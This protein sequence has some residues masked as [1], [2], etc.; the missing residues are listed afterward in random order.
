MP[1]KTL[2]VADLEATTT[3]KDEPFLV[4]GKTQA[5]TRAGKT[6]LNLVLAD[7]TGRVDAKVWD[8]ADRWARLFEVGDAV[9]VSAVGNPYQGRMQLKV[10]SITSLEQDAVSWDELVPASGLDLGEMQRELRGMLDAMAD[11]WIRAACLA[12][13]DDDALWDRFCA[14]SAAKTLHHAWRGGLLE[15]TLSVMRVCRALAALYP[16]VNPDLTLAGGLLHD[17]GKVVELGSGPVAAYSDHGRLVG[18]LAI[19]IGWIQEKCAAIPGFPE[20]LIW[21]LQHLVASHHGTREQGAVQVPMT[22]EAE[23][24]SLA[25]LLDSRMAGYQRVMEDEPEEEGSTWTRFS[26]IYERALYRGPRDWRDHG[27]P[28]RAAAPTTPGSLFDDLEE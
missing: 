24:L 28:S 4:A 7:R 17:M 26:R 18:H 20:D 27:A 5:T 13:V 9:A 12:F 23:I 21:H 19:C 8:D 15:H 11:P 25:D 1:A 2:F 3:L 14:A 22:L 16:A 6:Y 10:A